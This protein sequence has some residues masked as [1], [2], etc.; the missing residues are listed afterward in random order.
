MYLFICLNT[1]NNQEQIPQIYLTIPCRMAEEHKRQMSS[2]ILREVSVRLSANEH[3]LP[4]YG[5]YSTE[6][7]DTQEDFTTL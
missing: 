2:L 1:K 4:F 7:S 5:L 3:H 6:K